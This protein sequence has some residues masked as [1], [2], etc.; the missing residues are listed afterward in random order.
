[1][2]QPEPGWQP[3]PGGTGTSTLGRLARPASA[4]QEVVVKRLL[5]PAADDPAA[6]SQPRHAAYWRREADAASS[7]L[8]EHTPGLRMPATAVEEDAEGITLVQECVPTRATR[9]LFVARALGR[10][11]ASDVRAPVAGP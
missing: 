6:L 9:G 7:G 2:W 5:A 8:L 10:F 3:L 4:A 1:M 11:A